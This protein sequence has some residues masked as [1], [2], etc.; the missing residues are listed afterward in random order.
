MSPFDVVL[1]DGDHQ[2]EGCR[3]D[4]HTAI[5]VV[6]PG[7]V[8]AIHDYGVECFPGI[9]QAAAEVCGN[10]DRIVL[11]RTLLCLRVPE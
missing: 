3:E 1:V 11:E 6:K 2:F 5:E 10:W 8:V 9:P 4:L 7:G